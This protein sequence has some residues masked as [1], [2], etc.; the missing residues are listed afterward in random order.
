MASRLTVLNQRIVGCRLCPRLME[1]LKR[2][3]K[4]K[5]RAY[6]DQTYWS[7]PLPGFGHASARLVI[8]GLAPGGHG[9]NRT[10]RMFT[11]DAS[12]IFLYCALHRAGFANRD[13]SD[14]PNDSLL[15][16]DIFI[17]AVCRCA[18]PDNKPSREEQANC[19]MFLLE[20]LALLS[21]LEGIVVLG[22]IALGGILAA[23]RTRGF[24]FPRIDFSHNRLF[25][26]GQGLPW[27]IT[28]YHP[29]R[30]NTQTGRLTQMDFDAIWVRVRGLLERMK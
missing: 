3:A 5:R 13:H 21:H 22:R 2:V 18:P 8:I 23:Y 16:T 4:L 9:S 1:Y 20:E 10:G 26:M 6:R 17:T 24:T 25:E 29:S 27:L 14:D 28:S 15:L 7:R 11:G 30:Q 12:G 19:R